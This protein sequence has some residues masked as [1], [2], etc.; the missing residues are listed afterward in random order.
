[1]LIRFLSNLEHLVMMKAIRSAGMSQ[2]LL[3]LLHKKPKNKSL[4]KM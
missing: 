1:M 4:H 2:R 3:S